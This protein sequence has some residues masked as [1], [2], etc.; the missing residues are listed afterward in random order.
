MDP[1]SGALLGTPTA[2]GSSSFTVT[3]TDSGGFEGS[4]AY[5]F[6]VAP[7]MLTITPAANQS[8][9]YGSAVPTLTYT[10]TGLVNGDPASVLT[11]SLGTTATSSSPIGNYPF[12]TAGLKAGTNYTVLLAANAPTF[13]VAPATLVISADSATKT[14]GHTVTFAGTAFT[15]TGLVT[16][17]GDRITR[18]TETSTGAAASAA[19]A[20]SPYAIVPSAAVG[21]GLGNY[22]IDYVDGNLTVNTALLTIRADNASKTYGSTANFAGTAFTETGLVKANGD[23]ITSVTETSAGRRRRRRSARIRSCPAP[24]PGMLWA[25]TRLATSTALS[26]SSRMPRPPRSRHR[27]S[28]RSSASR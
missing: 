13:A 18:V 26:P 23:T 4:Q 5:T 8:I 20:G 17:N 9:V 12:T 14:Y 21:S 24:R 27:R 3:V 22:T 25:I 19:V 16:A 11:G 15:E 1:R 6:V 7:A 10:F 2:A 28:V